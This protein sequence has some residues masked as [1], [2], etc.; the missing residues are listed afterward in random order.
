MMN[1]LKTIFWIVLFYYFFIYDSTSAA[2]KYLK[3]SL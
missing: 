1:N 2:E 3:H